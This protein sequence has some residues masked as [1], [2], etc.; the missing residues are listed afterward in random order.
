[1]LAI[2]DANQRVL[3]HPAR[4]RVRK[5]IEDYLRATEPT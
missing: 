3:L 5:A 4:S 1:M 2:G